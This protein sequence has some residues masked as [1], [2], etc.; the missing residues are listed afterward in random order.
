M[1]DNDKVLDG[2][3]DDEVDERDS[4]RYSGSQH[5][6]IFPLVNAQPIGVIRPA[7]K[8]LKLK[9]QVSLDN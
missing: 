4:Q 7:L 9:S 5:F 3:A 6:K 1:A 2:Q 8:G